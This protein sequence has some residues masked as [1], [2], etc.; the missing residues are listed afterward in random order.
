[1]ESISIKSTKTKTTKVKPTYKKRINKKKL[2]QFALNSLGISI[3]LIFAAPLILTFLMSLMPAGELSILRNAFL[4][5]EGLNLG[6][7]IPKMMTIRQYFIVLINR[8]DFLNFFWNSCKITFPIVIGQTVLGSLAAYGFAKFKFP[9]RDKLFYIYVI[10]MLMPFQ[11]TLVPNFIVA[12][13]MNLLG[14]F[15]AIIL[16]GVFST[17][18][19]FY[20][21]QFIKSIP[22]E[23][24]EAA[25]IDGAGHLKIFYKII[26]PLSKPYIASLAVLSFIDAW[27]MVE[28]PLIMLPDKSQYPLSLILAMVGKDDFQIV[29]AASVIFLLPTLLLYMGTRDS[30]ESGLKHMSLK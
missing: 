29:F 13:K 25:K 24:I 16:P 1:M 7:M 12:I 21:R 6:H 30:L 20:M 3:C 26:V 2:K 19:I 11:V 28:Q 14:T 23:V 18:G 10:A 17:F 8:L 9:L 27:N 4:N 15:K 22:D 5:E